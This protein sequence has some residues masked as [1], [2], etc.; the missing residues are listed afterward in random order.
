LDTLYPIER[1]PGFEDVSFQFPRVFLEPVDP[2]FELHKIPTDLIQEAA[3]RVTD[4][5]D[6]LQRREIKKSKL[7]RLTSVDVESAEVDSLPVESDNVRRE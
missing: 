3:R 7:R 1:T 5:T 4:S 6:V 2:P